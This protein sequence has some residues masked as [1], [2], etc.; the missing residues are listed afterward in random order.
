MAAF[1]NSGGFGDTFC[2]HPW[3][4]AKIAGFKVAGICDVR[5]KSV[6][7]I[8]IDS[9][10]VKGRD[11]TRITVQGYKDGEFDIIAK[12]W[13]KE[14]WDS[15]EHLKEIILVRPQKK[16]KLA[17]IAMEVHHP[18]LDFVNISQAVLLGISPPEDGPEIGAKLVRFRMRE[19]SPP[20]KK[21]VTKKAKGASVGV[22]KPIAS[23]IKPHNAGPEKPSADPKKNLGPAG[24]PAPPASG[25]R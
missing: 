6:T 13:V 1:W 15:I 7:G 25:N 22:I 11:G 20:G 12:V 18:A 5:G 2:Q 23:G 9:A 10:K 16:A 14:Q 21:K 24:Q 17:D 4:L 3:G 19:F 8:E